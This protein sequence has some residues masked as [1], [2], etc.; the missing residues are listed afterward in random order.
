MTRRN[1]RRNNNKY[2]TIEKIKF[3]WNIHRELLCH[4]Q[5]RIW[6]TSANVAVEVVRTPALAA[7]RYE[8]PVVVQSDLKIN[9]L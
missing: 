8:E 2:C 9:D 6:I 5:F 3:H 7:T 1:N 4:L